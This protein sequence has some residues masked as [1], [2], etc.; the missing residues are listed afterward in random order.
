V[1]I[2]FPSLKSDPT[3]IWDYGYHDLDAI[4]I[5]KDVSVAPFAEILVH[6]HNR[7]S[8]L[9]G[10]LI[11]GDRVI[12]STGANIRAAGGVISIGEGSA[13]G[14]NTVIASGTHAIRPDMAR[15]NTP[16]D[17]SRSGVSIGKNV[18]IAA[19]CV[20]LPGVTI[21]DDAVISA[22]SLVSTDV[23]AAEIWRGVP[24]RKLVT[25]EE[26]ARFHR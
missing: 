22:G 11:I 2:R 16:Y 10:K 15:F 8:T 18:W 5:G 26:F 13:V 1:K 3:A 17:E 7:N 4:T 21:G 9:E 19:N 23:P 25:V 14:Q 20:V 12:I 6:K 24:A